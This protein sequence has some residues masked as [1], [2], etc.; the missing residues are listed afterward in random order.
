MQ[1]LRK[2]R[3]NQTMIAAI[4]ST[5]KYTVSR[6]LHRKRDFRSYHPKQAQVKAMQRR[7]KKPQGFGVPWFSRKFH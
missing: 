3:H 4:L 2:A 1:A 6:E 7:H 5:H